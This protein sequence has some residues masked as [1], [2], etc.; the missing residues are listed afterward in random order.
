MKITVL[1]C[2]G[3]LGVPV[4]GRDWGMCDPNN[5]KNHRFRASLLI[6]GPNTRILID[7]TPDV[8][9]QMLG[10]DNIHLDAVL[11]THHHADHCNGLDDL[12]PVAWRRKGA[13]P[14]YTD[15][16]TFAELS[17]RYNYVFKGL[18]DVE[19][20]MYRPYIDYRQID[21]TP[22]RINN[23]N[24][25]PFFQAHGECRSIGFRVGDFAYSTDVVDL[26]ARAFDILRGVK[27]WIVDATRREPHPSH[28]HLEKALSWIADIRPE[29][30]WLTH[31]NHTMDYQAVLNDCPAGVE[32]A[33][34][35]LEII[36]S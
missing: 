14:L 5:P 29:R 27:Y 35:G 2:G 21:E 10:L 4:I 11:I 25:Q 7:A 9:Q 24:F 26:D 28:A 33:Y 18:K 19:S 17:L 30:A 13:L 23:L 31:M 32:P 36:L 20:G 15:A 6:E 3:S 16:D 34:D 1:G 22:F 8:R 12:R